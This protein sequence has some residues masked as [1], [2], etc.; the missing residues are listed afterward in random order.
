M[1]Y[2]RRINVIPRG[3]I[4]L[5]ELF[6]QDEVARKPTLVP[7]EKVVEDVK[8]GTVD[9]Q[10]LVKLSKTLSPKS[11]AEYVKFLF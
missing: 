9:K 10:K 5:E 8:I 3:L 1:F 2:R 11:K 6:D 4:P 7:T